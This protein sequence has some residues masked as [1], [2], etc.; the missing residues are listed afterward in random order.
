LALFNDS[1]SKIILCCI[2]CY[3]FASVYTRH[4]VNST[5]AGH[6]LPALATRPASQ[7]WPATWQKLQKYLLEELP[8]TLSFKKLHFSDTF[9]L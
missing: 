6:F 3:C 8:T 9:A 5:K 7:K 1:F 2:E 4:V